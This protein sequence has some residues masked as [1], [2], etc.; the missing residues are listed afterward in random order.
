MLAESRSRDLESLPKAER[1][2]IRLVQAVRDEIG[3]TGAFTADLA[4]RR[5]GS[6]TATFYNHFPSKEVALQAVYE[7][8]MEELVESVERMLR[9]E[10]VLEV[11]LDAFVGEWVLD[12][13]SFF[14]RNARVFSAAQVAL[15]DSKAMREIFRDREA[16]ALEVYARFV[17]LGQAARVLR[18]GD[19]AAMAQVMM[20][21][22]EG[23]LHPSVQTIEAGD[24]F[25]T[26]LTGS[27]VRMLAPNE[28]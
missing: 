13:A 11:G 21:T 16:A 6:A 8:L 7:E 26:E 4:A 22:S 5:A 20:V 18:D 17:R 14:R 28:E 10:R 3:S 24:A 15:P 25:H 12:V 27:V 19:V 1:T 9:I 2:R 23:W